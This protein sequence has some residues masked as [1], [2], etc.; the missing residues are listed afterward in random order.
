MDSPVLC[1]RCFSN[2]GLSKLAAQMG[3]TTHD[4]CGQCGLR[5]G[6]KINTKEAHFIF[7]KFYII[8]SHASA[9]L[10]TVFLEGAQQESDINFENS[11]QCDYEM[12][13]KLLGFRLRRN[14]PSTVVLGHTQIRTELEETLR[15]DPN[16]AP[17]PLVQRLQANLQALLETGSVY[18]LEIGTS[19]YRARVS[20][21]KPLEHR[22]YDSPPIDRVQANR[23][24]RNGYQVLCG[25]FD[26]QTC[27]LEVRP[28]LDSLVHHKVF[29]ASL[30]LKKALKVVDFTLPTAAMGEPQMDLTLRAFFEANENSYHLTQSLS[31]FAKSRGYDGIVYPSALQCIS[32]SSESL[33]N[34][35]IFGTP[36]A[37]GKVEVESIN[38]MLV[39]S[40]V[41]EFELGP[42]WD[43]DTNGN[44]LAPFLRGWLNR[45]QR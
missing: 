23:I 7:E 3:S 4:E 39:R 16:A 22:E 29:L 2:T 34:V 20:P 41:N 32:G 35:A 44:H 15:Q 1:S 18:E 31:I 8:G 26:M 45:A 28:D 11:A 6:V 19:F 30:R 14:M 17:N 36:I 21:T 42:V 24:A 40:V 5:G 10:P 25:S 9:Y 13:S 37:E 38:R 12:L 33:R 27:L 43:D